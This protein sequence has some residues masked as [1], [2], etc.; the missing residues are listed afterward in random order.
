MKNIAFLILFFFIGIAPSSA[1]MWNGTDTLYGNEWIQWDQSYYKIP[2][3]ADAMYRL[4]AAALQ[5]IL[6]AGTQAKQL[7]VYYLGEEIPLF[8]TTEDE[9]G[10]GDYVEFFGRRNRSEL[11]RYLYTDPEL[12]L[13]PDYSLFT[14]TSAYFLTWTDDPSSQRY[15]AVT[16]DLS[17]L[18]PA[19]EYFFS[20]QIN[21][22][23]PDAI[24][25]SVK[26]GSTDLQQ[27]HFGDAEGF[28]VGFS[29]PLLRIFSIQPQG[30][31]AGTP[32]AEMSVTFSCRVGDHQQLV[33][34]D[35]TEYVN[36][37]FSGF[38]TRR[39]TF[40]LPNNELNSNM[41]VEIEG[42]YDE[43][44]RQAVSVI[45][46]RYPRSFDFG[47]ASS[48][49]FTI[50]ADAGKRYLEIENFALGNTPPVL[51]D[52]TNGTRL[53]ATVDAGLVRIGLPPSATDRQLLLLNPETGANT[54]STPEP[55]EFIDFTQLDAEFLIIYH[56]QLA[57]G[58]TDWIQ[59]Y[60]NYRSSQSPYPYSTA[61]A[62][63]QQLYDQFGYGIQRHSQ[64]LRNFIH[65]VNKEWS[66][67]RYLFI[68]G[69]GREYRHIRT[70]ADLAANEGIFYVP[71]FGFPGADNLLAGSNTSA[72]P[73]V[74][75][76]RLAATDPEEVRI[77]LDKVKAFEMAPTQLGQTIAEKA[78]MKRIMHLG[79]GG[80]AA[81]QGIIR[82][83]LKNMEEEIESNRF[84][85]EVTSFYK[86]SSDPIETS[87]SQ[88]L[89]DLINDGISILT[90]FGHSSA[91]TFDFNFDD[92]T[93]Y[94]N[95]GRYPMVFSLGCF[96]GQ[97]H[98]GT[99]GIGERFVLVDERGAAA[100]FASTGY[101][102]VSA[103]DRFADKFYTL[104]G[105][106]LYGQGIG[107][108]MKASMLQLDNSTVI[109]ERELA[110]QG[111][112]QGDP[113]L[114]LNVH[115]APDYLIDGATVDFTPNLLNLQL[116]SFSLAFDLVNIGLHLPDTTFILQI[117]Q[118]FPD[119]E[120]VTVVEASVPTP[121]F[122]E[123]M[124]FRIP[125]FGEESVGLNTF[126]IKAD[127]LNDIEE[128]P[129]GAEQNNELI[130]ALSGE[131]GV[132]IYIVS[133]DL[134]P[135]YPPEFSIVSETP[136]VL[137]A[138][139]ADAF[140]AQQTY[141][142]EIDTT[143]FFNSPL[144][145]RTQTTQS[146]GV[147][148]WQPEFDWQNETVYY[149]RVSPDSTI[150]Q[151]YRWR[152]SSFVFLPQETGGWNQSH[153]FQFSR[154]EF[155]NTELPED[156][157]RLKYIDDV[158][159][160]K[161]QNCIY[162]FPSRIPRYYRGNEALGSYIG[163]LITNTV[164]AGVFIAVLDT[165]N[166]LPIPSDGAGQ[167]GEDY[168][169][170]GF[171]GYI[172]KTDDVTQRGEVIDFLESIEPGNYV[173]FFTVQRSEN[174]SYLPED[175]A[176]DVTVLGTDL[177]QVLAAQ[178]ATLVQDLPQLG[179]RPYSLFF[180]KDDPS[181]PVQE[182]IAELDELTQQ[183]S[184]VAG[185]WFTGTVGSTLIGPAKSWQYL[186]W[187]VDGYEPATD[188]YFLQIE[189]IRPDGSDTL[190]IDQLLQ[191]DTSLQELDAALYPQL[192]LI[193]DSE[194]QT[195]KTPPHLDRW[196]VTYEGVPEAA[197]HPFG[198]LDLKADTLQQGDPLE[199]ALA[200]ENLSEYDMDSLLFRFLLQD[201]AN[202]ET[203]IFQR[204][205]PLP[206]GDTLVARFTTDTRGMAGHFQLT[207]EVNP[208]Q[209]QPEQTHAN[210]VGITS[211]F[212][213]PDGRNPLVDVT[214]DGVHILDGDLVSA[215]PHIVVA[216]DDENEFLELADTSLFRLLLVYPDQSVRPVYF[217]DPAV[218]FFPADPGTL[219]K[220]NRATIEYHPEFTQ[221]GLY[222]L[223]LAAADASGNESGDLN[224]FINSD[225]FGYD[226]KISFRVITKSSI[227]HLLNYPNPFSTSTRF[228]YTLTGS[229]P[230][231]YFKI[232]ILTVSGRIVRE[233]TQADLGL[234]RIGTHQTDLAWDGTDE[235]GD[236]LANGVYLY[237]VVARKANG[238]NID[239]YATDADQFFRKGFGKL[240]IIR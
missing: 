154:D 204:Y 174:D 184:A 219:D 234:L 237:R 102:F 80:S 117:D 223:Y 160:L 125:L 134:V 150:A 171:N 106:D 147:L 183:S 94:E 124:E 140:A 28:A 202:N 16:N 157:R 220:R 76:G 65:Y 105:G 185:N 64:A 123:K 19:D 98:S 30:F 146:G 161:I 156:T 82:N 10:A 55:V 72:I 131:A 182:T 7:R 83:H 41:T 165:V 95:A 238:E 14:D 93:T 85:G 34:V 214:F 192:R 84:G 225:E 142:W 42:V 59:E 187:Q 129:S 1:Q 232:Q 201:G 152:Q 97:C 235:F 27:S 90:F 116:D 26:I 211:F 153:F 195:F 132:Q 32:D 135:V 121:A 164:K 43:N 110:Q 96:S 163:S 15:Q 81:E 40:T 221:D 196:R 35:G 37:Q 104:L 17:N 62:E 231:A 89:K 48:F 236:R 70:A 86:E 54:V 206:A 87:Q 208:D 181:Y 58:S 18:P 45:S 239:N 193:Y 229:E 33:R 188:Q 92:P 158:I 114:R 138:S 149:W 5:S 167:Y 53:S 46:L 50:P 24:K 180:R 103:L 122:R 49:L 111:T 20:E 210:N 226:Y 209:D 12:L 39:H 130:N 127:A 186:H 177:Y 25:L 91:N 199:L 194:D 67:L 47:G 36:D 113:A 71:T 9:L 66:D 207:V 52:L 205:R 217:S 38:Q 51:Y 4:P 8:T 173:V 57:T 227:S 215:S 13:H 88:A 108:I 73:V 176:A 151:G 2:V 6:P 115:P 190:L 128:L 175:W 68:I 240:V 168:G 101:G 29:G 61:L 224:Y 228:V 3:A 63:V 218:G 166:I 118:E 170:A 119:G 31:F 78:W 126:Y 197:L 60:A 99:P 141:V 179:A 155:V 200:V 203:E 143:A 107:D 191:A 136:V 11:D 23:T 144:L 169:P 77:Y 109:G 145:R 56:E 212:V 74:P 137:K 172:F 79:G 213:R 216:V 162:D 44:D 198:Y 178:G 222:H 159:D 22:Y 133:N 120:R 100:Y 189:G 75:V 148:R 112:L 69:K 21:H 139:T 230:P 233:L